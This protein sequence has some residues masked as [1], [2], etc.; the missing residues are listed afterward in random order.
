[1]RLRSL[2]TRFILASFLWTGGLL[3]IAHMA[4]MLIIRHSYALL[5]PSHMVVL[6]LAI[7][8]MIAGFVGVRR[9]L[10]PFDELR[11]RLTSVREGHDQT[12]AGRI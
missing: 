4:S 7:P 6:S 5:V 8:C 9:G 11:K 3:A 12:L 2:K 1:M 10:S